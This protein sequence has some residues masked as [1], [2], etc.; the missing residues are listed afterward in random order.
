M[1]VDAKPMDGDLM[2]A[3]D[4]CAGVGGKG[5]PPF[6][7]LTDIE[8]AEEG[9]CIMQR[10]RHT[11]LRAWQEHRDA[12]CAARCYEVIQ[13]WGLFS[14]H[15]HVSNHVRATAQ[16]CGCGSAGSLVE[17]VARFH[18]SFKLEKTVLEVACLR[19]CCQGLGLKELGNWLS[20]SLL[21]CSAHESLHV[22]R[23]GL[24]GLYAA[25]WGSWR[26]ASGVFSHDH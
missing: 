21:H 2:G 13:F 11:K 18:K 6:Q 10:V 4:R 23:V 1:D 3:T 16:A 7:H 20:G 14:E 9:Q 24:C 15:E 26:S 22:W 19:Q 12:A 8:V 17:P 25:L 5:P